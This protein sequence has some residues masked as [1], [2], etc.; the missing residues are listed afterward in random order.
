MALGHTESGKHIIFRLLEP[1]RLVS[2]QY[3]ELLKDLIDFVLLIKAH[4]AILK[5]D[6]LQEAIGF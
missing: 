3:P 2:F 5:I 4:C 6:A 1:K